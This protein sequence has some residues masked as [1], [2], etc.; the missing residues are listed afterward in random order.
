MAPGVVRYHPEVHL[1]SKFYRKSPDS[2]SEQELQHYFLHRKNVDGLAPASMRLCSSGIRFFSQ[3]V[4]QRD[5]HT[6]SLIRAESEHR[7]PAVLS[8]EEVR[9][10]LMATTPLHNRAYFTTLSSLGLR[11]HEGLSLH[12][13]DIDS[14]RMMVH[15]HRGKGA[16]DRYVPLPDATLALLRAYWK[17][18]RHPTWLFPYIVPGGGLSKDRDAW[19]PSRANFYVPVRA[20]SPIYRAI[21]AEEIRT[22]RLLEQIDPQVWQ[23]PWNVHSQANPHGTTALKYLAPYVFKVAISNRRI[24]SLKDR[25]VTFTYRKPGSARPRTAQL[26]VLEFLRRF[27]QHVLPSG[28][29]KVHHFGFMSARC[30]ITTDDIRRMMPE[31][32]GTASEPPP[33]RDNPAT[34]LSCPHCGGE[35]RVVNRVWSSP[36]VLPRYRLRAELLK[37][38]P[39]YHPALAR[40]KDPCVRAAASGIS[41]RGIAGAR[42]IQMASTTRRHASQAANMTLPNVHYH[43]SG[44]TRYALL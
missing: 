10:L 14:Q 35:L 21:F 2:I 32:N 12:V 40:E 33:A 28:C 22:A 11:L 20:L 44:L 42:R 4:L 37:T 7:L 24:V 34:A 36:V 13:S 1:L 25:T 3:H 16:K 19:L 6:L 38:T 39:L 43:G 9:R 5:W 29:M 31:Q 8:V 30:T 17:T 27:L 15:V 26:D 18:H 23:M 41:G